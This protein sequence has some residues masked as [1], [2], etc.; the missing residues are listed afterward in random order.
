LLCDILGNSRRPTGRQASSQW[1]RRGSR[2]SIGEGTGF[3][4]RGI[5][6]QY[7]SVFLMWCWFEVESFKSSEEDFCVDHVESL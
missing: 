3:S 7:V 1:K 4:C 6:R 5:E 2:W